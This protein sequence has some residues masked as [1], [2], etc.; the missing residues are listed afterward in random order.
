MDAFALHCENL[1]KQ[2]KRA[3]LNIDLQNLNRQTALHNPFLSL[4][5]LLQQGAL[6]LLK[7][8]RELKHA[9]DTPTFLSSTDIEQ[10]SSQIE[11]KIY[12]ERKLYEKYLFILS[13]TFSAAPLLGLLGTVWGI[14]L[15][16]K[17]LPNSANA[18]SNGAVLSGL[19]VA[20]GTTVWGIVVAICAL[21]PYNY[22]KNRIDDYTVR[23][24]QFSTD[25]LHGVELQYRAVDVS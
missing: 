13:T 24:N 11:M 3:P 17:A 25:L 8:N 12:A 9:Q 15:T 20:L 19:S 7:K 5:T 6:S 10:L 21:V 18:L 1:L 22:I 23:M 4:Y 14:S 2:H 16:L